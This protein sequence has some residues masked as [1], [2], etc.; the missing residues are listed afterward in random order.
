[1][2]AAVRTRDLLFVALTNGLV[3]FVDE[4]GEWKIDP[5]F[6][7]TGVFSEGLCWAQLPGQPCGYIDAEGRWVIPPQ[8]DSA[9]DFH[10][11]LAIAKSGRSQVVVKRD[12]AVVATPDDSRFLCDYSEGLS[13]A[14]FDGGVGFLSEDGQWEFKILAAE[15]PQYPGHHFSEGLVD[16]TVD[17]LT[18]Y[19]DSSGNWRIQPA[20]TLADPFSEGLAAVA[21]DNYIVGFIDRD[22]RY[23]ITPSSEYGSA[24]AFRNGLAP[25]GIVLDVTGSYIIDMLGY[26]DKEGNLIGGGSTTAE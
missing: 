3:G 12:G 16:L 1:M 13:S 26:I 17:G 4:H 25:V 18:G 10:G 21:D 9:R 20:F 5:V 8:F 19:V 22:G 6:E 23:V 2:A 14:Q 24:G 11:G 15:R 7:Q